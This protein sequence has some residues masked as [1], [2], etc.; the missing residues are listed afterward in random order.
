MKSQ[1]SQESLFIKAYLQ[2]VE[3]LGI[4]F[5]HSNP[6][7]LIRSLT[8]LSFLLN[9]RRTLGFDLEHIFLLQ[10]LKL[11]EILNS[12]A[13]LLQLMLVEMLLCLS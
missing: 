2:R 1:T 5:M 6:L 12:F 3:L 13:T 11:I 10:F 4:L 8:V 7:D 9:A